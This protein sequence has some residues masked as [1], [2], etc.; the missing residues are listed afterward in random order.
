MR[1]TIS[2]KNLEACL[3]YTYVDK[4]TA[5]EYA[6]FIRFLIKTMKKEM[7]I[8]ILNNLNDTIIKGM[9]KDFSIEYKENAE[10]E[11]DHFTINLVEEGEEKKVMMLNIGKEKVGKD[12]KNSAK[13]FYRFYLY[14]ESN[15]EGYR[16]TFNRRV[17]KK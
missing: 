13:T 9:I 12:N 14:P 3:Q 7:P 6:S 4:I 5:S 17:T 10:G 1:N 8:E 2:S 11:E 15:E 16:V